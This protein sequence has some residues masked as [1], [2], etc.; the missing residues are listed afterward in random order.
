[1]QPFSGRVRIS[2]DVVAHNRRQAASFN[3]DAESRPADCVPFAQQQWCVLDVF[4][5]DVQDTLSFSR[6]LSVGYKQFSRYFSLLKSNLRFY[7]IKWLSKIWQ[8]KSEKNVGKRITPRVNAL[9]K[10]DGGC[11]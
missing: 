8:K 4:I 10:G 1:M 3:D 9:F 11:F 7:F 5:D 6:G 2:A